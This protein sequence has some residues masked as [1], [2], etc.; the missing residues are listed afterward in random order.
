MIDFTIQCVFKFLCDQRA[1][2]RKKDMWKFNDQKDTWIE[3]IK[4]YTK[5][6]MDDNAKFCHDYTDELEVNRNYTVY[7]IL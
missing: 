1:G 2:Y 4:Y 5:L 6:I 3:F 7:Y